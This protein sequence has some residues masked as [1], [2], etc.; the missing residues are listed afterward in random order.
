MKPSK[1]QPDP[2]TL[3]SNPPVS[4]LRVLLV[5]TPGFIGRL[6]RWQTRGPYVHAALM[7]DRFEIIESKA[8]YGVIGANLKEWNSLYFDVFQ[9][10]PSDKRPG[11]YQPEEGWRFAVQQIGKPYD[12]SMVIRFVTRQQERRA[13]RGKWFCSELVF[14]ALKQAG[15]NVLS[16]TE[17]WEVSPN[18]LSKSP[19]LQYLGSNYRG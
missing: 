19:Y 7:N 4:G 1:V 16:R 10:M 15:V 17:P 3:I 14:A 18:L 6:I 12:Y 2:P 8:G 11:I 5:R 13:S 9:V